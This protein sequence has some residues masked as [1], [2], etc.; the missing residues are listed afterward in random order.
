MEPAADD[1][2][3]SRDRIQQ[4]ARQHLEAGDPLGWFE[5]VYTL[6]DGQ[7]DVIPWADLEPHPKLSELIEQHPAWVAGKR[8]LVVGCGLG[9][10]AH[11]LSQGGGSVSAFDLSG[12]AIEW[13]R[14]RFSGSG[15]EFEVANLL[16]L[17]PRYRQAFDLVVE[18]F[19]LQALPLSLRES[20]VRSVAQCVAPGGRLFIVCR[21]R[22][23]HDVPQGPPWALSRED[24]GPIEQ[25]G[26]K[27]IELA[28]YIDNDEP[29]QR[30]F[31]ATWQ[32]S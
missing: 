18:I 23:D 26:M 2:D 19:T 20:A 12:T 3:N 13:A 24:L 11:A 4:V 30:R 6:A 5:A 31:A 22:N 16:E 21:A 27:L 10:D 8:V 7:P 17:A 29:P 28:D 14:Q 9:D 15:I 25:D 1:S 32:R